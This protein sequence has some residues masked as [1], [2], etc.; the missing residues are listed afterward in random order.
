MNVGLGTASFGTSIPEPQAQKIL[1]AFIEVG[2]TIIDTANNYAFWAGEGGESEKVIGKWLKTKNREQVEIHTKIGAL[3]LD[4]QNFSTAEGLS[5]SS[6][7]NA[8]NAS[9]SRL[10]THYIDVLYAHIDDASTPLLETW[11]ALSSLV[12][13]GVVKQ[14]GISNYSL[15]RIIELQSIIDHHDL[16]PISY[17]QYRHTIIEPLTDA[18]LGVQI[19]FSPEIIAALTEKNPKIKLVAYSPLLGG[20]FELGRTLPDKYACDL[21]EM[22]VNKVREEAECSQI[23]PS[24][25]VLKKIAQ[26]GVMPLTI[27][28]KVER[29]KENIQYFC[30][31]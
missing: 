21:N 13:D 23:S 5:K 17:A 30:E 31:V 6:I 14:L 3:P 10:S 11:L 22:R 16:I 18:D 7:E 19:C 8:V 29:L 27:S 15:S 25:L 28:S 4:G 24:A 26:Q 2:G 9:L 20:S 12:L 1:N